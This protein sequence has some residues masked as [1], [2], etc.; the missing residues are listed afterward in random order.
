MTRLLQF[1]AF[2]LLLL[3]VLAVVPASMLSQQQ[4]ATGATVL[5]AGYSPLAADTGKLFVMECTALCAI[6][7]P[8]PPP[9]NMWTIWVEV[10]GNGPVSIYPNGLQIN[11]SILNIVMPA[12]MGTTIQITTDGTNYYGNYDSKQAVGMR[13]MDIRFSPAV[14]GVTANCVATNPV[15]A[16]SSLGSNLSNF[17]NTFQVNDGIDLI[18]CGAADATM[19]TPTLTT[20]APVID[21][22]GIGTEYNSPGDTTGVGTRYYKIVLRNKA[23][24]ITAASNEV[25]ITDGAVVLG[26]NQTAVTS[27]SRNTST[28]VVTCTSAAHHLPIGCANFACGHARFYG[29]T[30]DFSFGGWINILSVADSTHFTYQNG[31]SA[32]AGSSTSATGGTLQYWLG[33]QITL[34]AVTGDGY[35]YGIYEGATSGS[36]VWVDSTLPLGPSGDSSYN[37]YTYWGSPISANTVQPPYWPTNPPSSARNNT[38]VTTITA[39][40]GLNATLATAPTVT[41]SG[42]AALFDLEP[43][44]VVSNCAMPEVQHWDSNETYGYVFN[45]YTV[46]PGITYGEQLRLGDTLETYAIS[47][48]SDALGNPFDICTSFALE[49]QLPV[50]VWGAKPGVYL[51]SAASNA[52]IQ[53]YGNSGVGIYYV[54]GGTGYFSHV[55]FTSQGSSIDYK[56]IGLYDFEDPSSGGF[57]YTMDHITTVSGPAQ[58][59]GVTSAPFMISKN[60]GEQ[61]YTY[62][63]GDRRGWF[64]KPNITGPT[65]TFSLGQEMQGIITPTFTLFYPCNAG[66]VGGW[67]NFENSINDTSVEPA[68]VTGCPNA[69]GSSITLKNVVMGCCG[70]AI[71]G[72]PITDLTVTGVGDPVQLGQNKNIHVVSVTGQD[73]FNKTIFM[74]SNAAALAFGQLPVP[75]APT[76]ALSTSSCANVLTTGSYV[77]GVVW[78]DWTGSIAGASG[79]ATTLGPYSSAVTPNGTTQCVQI[80][81]P[82]VPVGAVYW[83]VFRSINSGG[84]GNVYDARNSSQCGP[85]LT[86]TTTTTIFDEDNF[87]CAG[88][89][90]QNTTSV[91]S[92]SPSGSHISQNTPTSTYSAATNPLPTCN[93]ANYNLHAVVSDATSPSYMGAYTSG[94]AVT[95]DVICS[96]NGSSYSWL[97]H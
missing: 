26:E 19:S 27:C 76:A 21:Q 39:L 96:F 14:A 33:D 92:L 9:T 48:R 2:T 1:A 66:R 45:S 8:N 5:T 78:Y 24:G 29:T 10:A 69:I 94:G 43:V 42:A 71:S 20:V 75:A 50:D 81:E 72:S 82:A 57:G 95:A 30:D 6:T 53:V 41:L 77:Y 25:S 65:N 80:T 28:D 87:T 93:A 4:C 64:W 22:G 17:Q 85:S 37:K 49:C 59:P 79:N 60:N 7:L 44:C 32:S 23:Q 97:T 61:H 86:L 89:P 55:V 84:I 35:E 74:R 73:F 88:P 34:P 40:S 58:T 31:Q 67:F 68:I 15:V 90:S 11:K 46:Y 83:A 63:G 51:K 13:T 36:E 56:N 47:T 52:A 91:Q 54:N 3:I 38:L 62:T 16:L 18:G 12:T 70:P